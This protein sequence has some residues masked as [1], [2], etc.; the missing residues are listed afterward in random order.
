M[1]AVSR[2]L[3]LVANVSHRMRCENIGLIGCSGAPIGQTTL[4]SRFVT[5]AYFEQ[6]CGFYFPGVEFTRTAADNNLDFMGWDISNTTRLMFSNG[7]CLHLYC[8]QMLTLLR[9]FDPWRS[10]GVSSEFRPSGPVPS[11]SEMPIILIPGAVHTQD[12]YMASI[13][14]Y[15]LHAQSQEVAQIVNWIKDFYQQTLPGNN[16]SSSS[17]CSS[18]SSV[19]SSH[20]VSSI[21]STTYSSTTT[22]ISSPTTSMRART[23]SSSI[24][25]LPS[26]S[27]TDPNRDH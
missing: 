24:T 8:G 19:I 10:A 6:E 17:T 11:T 5:T 27:L 9:Q 13:T 4:V 7:Y 16:S 26:F 25:S 21:Y 18:T 15:I 22:S 14:S 23:R 2:R 20:T 1:D 12:L 3:W